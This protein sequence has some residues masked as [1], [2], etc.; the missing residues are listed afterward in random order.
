[1]KNLKPTILFLFVCLILSTNAFAQSEQPLQGVIQQISG[2]VE[3]KLPGAESFVAA[4]IGDN[5]NQNTIVSTGLKSFAIIEIGN[6][7]ITI[8]PITRL[9]LLEI[10]SNE[11]IETL[12]VN[13]QSGRIR[14][15][16]NPPAGRQ[17]SFSVRS[18]ESVA[19]VRGTSFEFDTRNLYVSNGIVGFS[20]NR[21]QQVQV[22]TGDDTRI[23]ADGKAVNPTEEKLANLMPPMPVGMDIVG[24]LESS[25]AGTGVIIAL[26]LGPW[27]G[28]D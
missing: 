7:S 21:G 16:V 10:H 4:Q 11:N 18:P 26:R 20:G 2:N 28:L 19:S 17:A 3:I 15:E 1:M 13:L 22:K 25:P 27:L 5:I 8:R 9:T 12:N 23:T 6:S 24:T 14:V